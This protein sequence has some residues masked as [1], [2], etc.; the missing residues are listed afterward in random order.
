MPALPND[1]P[2][3]QQPGTDLQPRHHGA[4]D[5]PRWRE[6]DSSTDPKLKGGLRTG[7]E[8]WSIDGKAGAVSLQGLTAEERRVGYHFLTALPSLL[9]SWLMSTTCVLTPLPVGPEQTELQ[10]EWLFPRETL[11]DPAFICVTVST[12]LCG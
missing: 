9:T 6:H 5:D 7:A 11:A 12:L 4:A 1:A 8:S 3:A 10:A 2:G